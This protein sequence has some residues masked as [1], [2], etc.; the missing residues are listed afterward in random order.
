VNLAR[1]SIA[2]GAALKKLDN[3]ITFCKG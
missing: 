3:L 2:S 1:D